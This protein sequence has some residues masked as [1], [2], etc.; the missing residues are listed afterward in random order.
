MI[1]KYQNVGEEL[2]DNILY[3]AE[4]NIKNQWD[5]SANKNAEDYSLLFHN[6]QDYADVVMEEYDKISKS[7]K[8]N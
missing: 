7:R 4:Q 3:Q 8:H 1:N 5:R 6:C 2:D